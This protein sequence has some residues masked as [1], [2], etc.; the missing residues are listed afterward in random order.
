MKQLSSQYAGIMKAQGSK[1]KKPIPAVPQSSPAVT[2][3]SSSKSPSIP[4]H[5]K[6]GPGPNGEDLSN[7]VLYAK[8]DN[9]I[10]HLTVILHVGF[11]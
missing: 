1:L 6:T 2:S 5:W 9:V 10:D 4:E 3:S 7:E 8:L 11:E